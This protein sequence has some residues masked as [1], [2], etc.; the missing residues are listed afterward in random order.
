MLFFVKTL[1]FINDVERKK[2][3]QIS[4]ELNEIIFVLS[5][6]VSQLANETHIINNRAD[7]V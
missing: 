3:Q 7:F 5:V 6:S 2:G 1:T 4:A